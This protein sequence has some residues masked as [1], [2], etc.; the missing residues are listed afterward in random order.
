MA[1]LL[2][3]RR[4]TRG[5]VAATSRA[6]PERGSRYDCRLSGAAD[7]RSASHCRARLRLPGE[8]EDRFMPAFL[9]FAGRLAAA[10]AAAAALPAAADRPRFA[11]DDGTA[12]VREAAGAILR[13]AAAVGPSAG[14]REE[15]LRAVYRAAFDGEAIAARVAGPA[16]RGAEAARRA[17]F[18]GLLERYFARIVASRLA[19]FAGARI[20]VAMSEPDGAGLAVY[21]RIVAR[22]GRHALNLRWRLAKHGAD[23]RIHDIAVENVSVSLHLRRTLLAG[24]DGRGDPLGALA[25]QIEALLAGR[26]PPRSGAAH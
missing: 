1:I 16:W 2:W 19:E 17:A 20:E 24:A 5:T 14:A 25:G 6:R 23:F 10:L 3:Q 18:A 9:R 21:S 26:T 13:A 8:T 7:A 15:G 11:A 22:D 12:F 4:R